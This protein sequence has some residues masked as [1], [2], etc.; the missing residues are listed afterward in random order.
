MNVTTYW[1]ALQHK[2]GAFTGKDDQWRT[3]KAQVEEKRLG[4]MV[5]SPWRARG[6]ASVM[7]SA[8]TATV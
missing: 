3:N 2:G 6:H 1:E 7:L 5:R 4:T 8:S